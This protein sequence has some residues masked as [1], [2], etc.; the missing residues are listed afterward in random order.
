MRS[1]I[2]FPSFLPSSLA[3][4][5][6]PASVNVEYGDF[7]GPKKPF[8]PFIIHGFEITNEG[9]VFQGY[10]IDLKLD[11]SLVAAGMKPVGWFLGSNKIMIKVPAGMNDP[12]IN[13]AYSYYLLE[14]LNRTVLINDRFHPDVPGGYLKGVEF[15]IF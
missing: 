1:P 11:R 15:N 3:C 6:S 10:R 7:P 9:D 13:H 8:G 4:F 2:V 5:H 14:F 12:D